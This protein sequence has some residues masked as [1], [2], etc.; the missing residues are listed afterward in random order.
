MLPKDI[1]ASATTAASDDYV[2]LNGTTNHSRKILANL[3]AMVNSPT[4]TGVPKAPTPDGT[5]AKALVTVDYNMA[6]VSTTT[7]TAAV[8]ATLSALYPVGEILITHRSGNP[9]TWLSFGTWVA[10]GAGRTLIGLDTADADY[11][12]IDNASGAKTHTITTAELPAHTHTT[13]T[14]TGT[15][16]AGSA[17]S[18]TA[19]VSLLATATGA[20]T[21]GSTSSSTVDNVSFGTAAGVITPNTSSE[22]AHTHSFTVPAGTSGSIGSGTAMSIV[23][24][25]ITVAMWR[26][27]A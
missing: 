9:A 21:N 20:L 26:R 8:A 25:Y 16:G 11:N 6:T 7:V 1:P 24:P 15:T 19:G 22:S 23:Q 3:W 27:T 12:A 17:H 5:Q 18:H 13:P 10:Y 2:H 4:F 14:Y